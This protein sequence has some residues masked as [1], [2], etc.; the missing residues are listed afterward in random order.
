MTQVLIFKSG[1]GQELKTTFFEKDFSAP[2]GVFIVVF[3]ELP[4]RG[5][6]REALGSRLGPENVCENVVRVFAGFPVKIRCVKKMQNSL[7]K[8]LDDDSA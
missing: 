1:E 8:P 4:E 7:L 3:Q 2:V 5:F 6:R